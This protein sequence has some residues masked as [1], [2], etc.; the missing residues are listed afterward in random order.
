MAAKKKDK[1]ADNWLDCFVDCVNRL[2]WEWA[3]VCAWLCDKEFPG[4]MGK[5]G[6]PIPTPPSPPKPSPAAPGP[7]LGSN[8]FPCKDE[9]D[10]NPKGH[11]IFDSGDDSERE[12]IVFVSPCPGGSID[13]VGGKPKP[14]VG[15]DPGNPRKAQ[16]VTADSPCT[17]IVRGVTVGIT[18]KHGDGKGVCSYRIVQINK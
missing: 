16:R 15:D 18:C 11:L 2:G 10:D 17:V 14:K 6:F 5:M 12:I 1:K 7:D 13:V 4:E 8:S 3:P 9:D